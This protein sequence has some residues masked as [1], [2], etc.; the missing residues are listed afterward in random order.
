MDAQVKSP[1]IGSLRQP[2]FPM[3]LALLAAVFFLE[4]FLLNFLIDA[5]AVQAAQRVPRSGN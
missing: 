2:S 1:F 3:R 5:D 4:K